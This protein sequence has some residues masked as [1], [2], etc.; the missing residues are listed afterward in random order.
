VVPLCIDPDK[1][2]T[3]QSL[4]HWFMDDGCRSKDRGVV[5]ATNSFTYS[6]TLFLAQILEKKFHLK[7]SLHK[8]GS[9]VRYVIYIKKLVE[10]LPALINLIK[11]YMVPS[12]FYKYFIN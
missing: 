3:A 8:T 1:F 12:M 5:I 9:D 6:E 7:T 11:P 4:C 10:S 2:L